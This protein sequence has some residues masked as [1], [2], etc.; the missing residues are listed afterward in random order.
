MVRDNIDN[1]DNIDSEDTID[2]IAN[3]GTEKK[4]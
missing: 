3:E 1:G 4:L 2:S